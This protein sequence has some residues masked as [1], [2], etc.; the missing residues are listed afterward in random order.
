MNTYALYEGAQAS[1]ES[2][3]YEGY[4]ARMYRRLQTRHHSCNGDGRIGP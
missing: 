4:E 3:G 2:E 1:E